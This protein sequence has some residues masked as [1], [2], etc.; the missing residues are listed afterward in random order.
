MKQTYYYII[1]L[2][3]ATIIVSCREDDVIFIPE[4][5][6]VAAAEPSEIAGFYLLNEGNM[7]LNKATLDYFDYSTGVYTR[8]IYGN[9]N[10]GVPKEMGDVGN[11]LK[12]YG[13]RMYAVI[14]CSNKVEVMRAKDAVR[15][16]QIDI[17]NCRDIVFHEGNAYVSSYA[18]PV[19]MGPE[20]AQIGYVARIDTLTLKETG[21]VLTG[22]QPDGMAIVGDKLYVA[23]SGGY[24]APNYENTVTVIDL[25]SFTAESTITIA[26]NLNHIVAD[27]L[28]QL[29]ITSRGNYTDIPSRLFCYDTRKERITARLD[30]AATSMSLSGDKLYIVA[31][32]WNEDK[33]E[34]RIS[35]AIVDVRSRQ[36]VSDMF[37]TD[38]TQEKIRIPYSVKVNPHTGEIFVGDARNYVNPGTL[39][40]FTAGGTLKWSVRT[41][42]IPA[43]I[44][45]TAK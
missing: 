43:H 2:L 14:N 19:Q 39:Y 30:V 1:T 23:N 31:T 13:S 27:G 9:A 33:T 20:H 35:Y 25:R 22:Y 18:G 8:N 12:I 40:C 10:P 24:L 16:G 11:A 17:P 36:K 28:G 44:A 29:W 38:G 3:L 7:G 45:F 42:D 41:G 5:V 37:I 4:E 26:E 34:N 15:I 32:E 21:R 6:P